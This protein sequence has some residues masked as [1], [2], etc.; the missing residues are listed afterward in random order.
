MWHEDPAR[1]PS[2]TSIGEEL[3]ELI[4]EVKAAKELD[5]QA[6]KG[7]SLLVEGATNVVQGLLHKID[8]SVSRASIDKMVVKDH[9]AI[10]RHDELNSLVKHDL[11]Y[12]GEAVVGTGST[13][14]GGDMRV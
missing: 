8:S 6:R 5:A 4:D 13:G 10:V 9:D 7:S 12:D 14:S 1:R 3:R 11:D 2:F